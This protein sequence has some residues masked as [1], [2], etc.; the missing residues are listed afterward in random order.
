MG[1][2]K[3]V[4]KVKIDRHECKPPELPKLSEDLKYDEGSIWQCGRR[5]CL[6]EYRI[7][8][9]SFDSPHWEECTH[10]SK[11]C[12]SCG[13]FMRRVRRSGESSWECWS[14]GNRSS[15]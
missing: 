11:N 10:D 14:C 1:W 9:P 2:V 6:R 15:R 7:I 3:K 12:E 13:K 4:K 5:K 8:N